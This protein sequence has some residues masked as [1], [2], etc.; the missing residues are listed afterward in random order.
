M[1]TRKPWLVFAEAVRLPIVSLPGKFCTAA[2]KRQTFVCCAV[3][4]VKG[5][6]D[7]VERTAILRALQAIGALR[8]GV[9]MGTELPLGEVIL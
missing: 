9:P 6:C 4:N 7:N 2:P 5:A 1:S 8:P 3:P